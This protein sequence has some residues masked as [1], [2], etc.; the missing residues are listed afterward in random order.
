M[1]KWPSH[2]PIL[3]FLNPFTSKVGQHCPVWPTQWLA[4]PLPFADWSHWFILSLTFHALMMMSC[5][6]ACHIFKDPKLHK[7][8]SQIF[9]LT[10][11]NRIQFLFKG[12]KQQQWPRKQGINPRF[13][14]TI[15]SFCHVWKETRQLSWCDCRGWWWGVHKAQTLLQLH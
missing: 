2:D 1:G 3:N 14:V 12:M 15:H 13:F 6:E 8:G 5:T 7:K 4:A 9:F 11:H 10:F